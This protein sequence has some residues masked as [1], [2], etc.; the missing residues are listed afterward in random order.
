MRCLWLHHVT[1]SKMAQN[2]LIDSMTEEVKYCYNLCANAGYSPSG[3][4]KSVKV[5]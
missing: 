3:L 4:I 1:Q 5:Y 2:V